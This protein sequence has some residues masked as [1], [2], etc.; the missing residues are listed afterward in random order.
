MKHYDP[1][2]GMRLTDCCATDSKFREI[3]S[4]G[5]QELTCRACF[6]TVPTGQGDGCEFDTPENA[7]AFY[8][9]ET[10]GRTQ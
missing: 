7:E 2:T 3:S 8:A 6:R 10:N 9:N 5:H 4:C 1:K